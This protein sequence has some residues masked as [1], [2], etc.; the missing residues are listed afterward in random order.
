MVRALAT[1]C[2]SYCCQTDLST[3]DHQRLGL[4]L[5]PKAADM[6]LEIRA[7]TSLQFQ[8]EAP[9]ASRRPGLAPTPH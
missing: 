3:Q 5:E 8:R 1:A 4:R 7:A 6:H 9:T 2:A